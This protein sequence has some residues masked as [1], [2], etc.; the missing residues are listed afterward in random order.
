MT[1]IVKLITFL[2][3][4]AR[5]LKF[6]RGLV[7]LVV[8]TGIVSGAAS[9]GFIALINATLNQTAPREV[10]LWGFVGLCVVLPVF[11]FLSNV[12]LVQ[13]V[14][15]VL[16]DLRLHLSRRILATPLRDLEEI[17]PARLLATITEDIGAI[18]G[19]IGNLPMLVLHLTVVLC[20]LI[21][22]GWLSSMLL[23]LVL[24]FIAV[25]VLSY[26]LPLLRAQR[27]FTEMREAWDRMFESLRGLTEGTKELKIHGRRREAFVTGNLEPA[28]ERLRHHTVVGNAI[29]GAANSW[30]QVLF[31][32]VIGLLLFA[33]PRFRPIDS[34]T[35]TGFTLVLLYLM[36]PLDVLLN[37][38]PGMGRAAVSARKVEGFGLWLDERTS[39]ADATAVPAKIDSWNRIEL[40]GVTHAYRGENEDDSFV[41]GPVDLAFEPGVCTFI[42]GGNGSGKTTLGKLLIGLY[43][44][45]EGEIL[46]DGEPVGDAERDRYRQLFSV[47][48]SDFYLFES[49]LGLEGP[50]LDETARRYLSQLHLDRKVRVEDGTLSTL[51]LSQGQR[52][53]LAL[54]TAYLEDREIYLFD[55]WA[56]DQDPQFK[57]IFYLQLLPELKARGKSVFVISHDD[58]Y[59]AVADRII[60]LNYG[61]VELDGP[62]DA[63]LAGAVRPGVHDG[64]PSRELVEGA[65][66]EAE[67]EAR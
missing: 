28:A 53:R 32:V 47:V 3:K 21:Y 12:L 46:L 1:S 67:V 43:D 25:G 48:F 13:L 45:E 18:V 2:I 30:G 56:A 9:T 20:C 55:E 51:E 64:K 62:A 11:R 8:V 5:D 66:A 35:A 27:H 23:L 39:D 22:L 42:I 38:L 36:T 31:F 52:K 41:L 14:Q 17:G 29:Y 40:R 19:A 65:V 54:L 4:C 26:Q 6:S 60:K 34:T 49:L 24:G 16:L 57:E 44:P 10:L 7:V 15:R 59:Y 61:Q 37:M 33:L 50:E 58:H 63:Y